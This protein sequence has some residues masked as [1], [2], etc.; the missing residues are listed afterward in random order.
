MLTIYVSSCVLFLRMLLYP[1]DI[2]TNEYIA[3]NLCARVAMLISLN[4]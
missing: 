2:R 1:R 4:G 3:N